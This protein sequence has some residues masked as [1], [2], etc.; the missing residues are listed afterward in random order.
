MDLGRLSDPIS[1]QVIAAMLDR[2]GVSYE[3]HGQ[4]MVVDKVCSIRKK[5]NSG[6]YYLTGEMARHGNGIKK[7]IIIVD[8]VLEN[9]K[10]DNSFVVVDDP[11]LV[12]YKICQLLFEKE[13]KYGVHPTAVIH[14]EA[15]ID[16]ETYI[17]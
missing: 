7:S 3:I 15:E 4:E 9:L 8:E 16:P 1:L 12:F 2:I 17:G 10:G 6:L 14:E 13:K 11:Q 5:E